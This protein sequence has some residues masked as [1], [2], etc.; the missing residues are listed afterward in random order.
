M[1]YLTEPLYKK[2][3]LFQ[4]PLEA[5]MTLTDL[6]ETF[7]IEADA[8]LLQELLARDEWYDKYLPEP[9][10][11]QLFD[12]HGE[13]SFQQLEETLLDQIMAFRQDVEQEWAEATAKV[14]QEKQ[15]LQRTATPGLRQLLQLDLAESEIRRITGID[16][17]TVQIELYPQWDMGKILTLRFTQVK[18]SWMSKM[19]PDDANWWL[20]DEILTD[21]ERENRYVL[22]ALFG[23]AEYVGHLQLTF[24]DVQVSERDDPLGF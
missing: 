9:L 18:E 1:R 23:N 10:H 12:S 14:Q 20:V 4:L 17:D 21:E 24:S 2:M 8:F 6:E 19:H 5:G 3:Q 15:L 7:G 16:S 22:Q 11:S 13:V